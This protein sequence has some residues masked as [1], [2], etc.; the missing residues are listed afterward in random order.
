[1]DKIKMKI[2]LSDMQNKCEAQNFHNQSQ[3]EQLE[4]QLSTIQ[5]MGSINQTM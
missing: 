1:M 2:A 4:Q 3:H 5:A